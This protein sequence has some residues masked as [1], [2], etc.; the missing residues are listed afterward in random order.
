M[1]LASAVGLVIAQL[2][3]PEQLLEAT[4][5]IEIGI[6]DSTLETGPIIS[7]AAPGASGSEGVAIKAKAGRA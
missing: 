2:G 1:A 6:E 4:D 5:A 3:G 7:A